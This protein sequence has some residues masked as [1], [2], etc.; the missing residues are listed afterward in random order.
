MD[1]GDL[2]DQPICDDAITDYDRARLQTYLRLLDAAAAGADWREAAAV[3]LDLDVAADP[4]RARR[5][6]QVHL[7]RARWMSAYGFAQLKADRPR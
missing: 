6:H 4:E 7:D 5:V 1:D 3:I 2:R